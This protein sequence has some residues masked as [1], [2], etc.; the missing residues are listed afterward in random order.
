MWGGLVAA[1]ALGRGR[2]ADLDIVGHIFFLRR[3]EGRYRTS[4]R[5]SSSGC[6]ASSATPTSPDATSSAARNSIPAAWSRNE[7]RLIP[8]RSN[9]PSAASY[10]ACMG[11]VGPDLEAAAVAAPAGSLPRRNG[12]RTRHCSHDAFG[13]RR[14]PDGPRAAVGDQLTVPHL[15]ELDV[16]CYR[17]LGSLQD[18]EDALQETLLA[19]W[20][21]IAGFEG[22]ASLRTWPYQIATNRCLNARRTAGHRPA[23]E[24]D[25]PQVETA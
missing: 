19:V 22:R 16:H 21:G 7:C 12:G 1:C 20:K 18:A 8:D 10:S 25:V 24:W 17:M 5:G 9:F 2:Q 13:L 14:L 23:E 11:G 3:R 6:T 4:N 15:R